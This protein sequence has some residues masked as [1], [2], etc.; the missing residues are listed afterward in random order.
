[1]TLIS[2]NLI[3]GKELIDITPLIGLFSLAGIR[4]LPSASKI[5]SSLQRLGFS[6]S[7]KLVLEKEIDKFFVL[8]ANQKN[9]LNTTN[10]LGNFK[11][12]TLENVYFSYPENKKTILE[13]INLD[14][15]K[16]EFITII[17]KSG[18]GKTTLI[19]IFLG[20]IKASDGY[21]RAN[22]KNI[23]DNI[24]DWHSLIGH[25]P[26]DVYLLDDTL[27][28]NIAV[29]VSVNDIN[30]K[31]LR[32]SIIQSKLNKF[33]KLSSNDQK[34]FIGEKGIKISGGQRQRIGIARALYKDPEILI[35]DEATS[36]L[37]KTTERSL[38]LDIKKI[39]KNKTIIMATHR[40]SV[41]EFSSKAF[42]IDNKK[43]R[44]LK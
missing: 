2:Y 33:I 32:K 42:I 23:N 4:L 3:L 21:V 26:Q 40:E 10:T 44:I 43:I 38:L 6:N 5:I 24:Q 18:S 22:N 13:N 9:L 12:L 1:M 11:K 15:L 34:N 17:G 37:D 16:G 27:E 14:I 19:N 36:A 7:V 31:R 39:N 25:V 35:F 30:L 29:G 41:L 28:A 20:L 8:N